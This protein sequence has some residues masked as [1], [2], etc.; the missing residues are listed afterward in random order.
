M[1]SQA[2]PTAPTLAPGARTAPAST[3]GTRPTA[4]KALTLRHE[5]IVLACL[6]VAAVAVRVWRL[7]LA[8]VQ[9]DES[10]AASLVMAWRLD[11]LF[12]IAGTV[13]SIG[14]AFPPAWP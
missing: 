4:E 6:L 11:G 8:Q 9:F 2:H 1:L 3:S 14:L 13:S 7:D 12:P 5:R 10:D